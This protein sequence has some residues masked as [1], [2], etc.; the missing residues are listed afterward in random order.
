MANGVRNHLLLYLNLGYAL[1]IVYAS[2][3]PLT[4]WHDSGGDPL[5]FVSAP[6]PRYFTA[7]DLA[8]NVLAYLPFG[9]LCAAALRG[10][11]T[12]LAAGLIAAALGAGLSLALELTQNYLPSRVPSNLDF[13]CNAAGA[14][15]GAML[16]AGW[17]RLVLGERHLALWQGHVITQAYGADLGV[18]LMAAWLMTQLSP[19]TLLFG[20]GDLRQMLDL[21][22]VQTFEP[23]RFVGMETAVAASGLLAA[24]LIASLLLRRRRR[25]LPLLL[26]LLALTTKTLAYALIAGPA[27]AL[28]WLTPGNSQGI[29]IGLALWLGASFLT[30]ALQRATAALALLFAT[31]M[32]NAAPEN[33]YL[34]NMAQLWHSGQFLNFNGLTRLI[35]SLWPFLALPWLM[36]YRP[37]NPHD[38]HF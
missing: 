29:G 21:P 34:N 4:G 8:T 28:T 24:T 31:V 23:E 25:L 1:L 5:S 35:C 2:L 27:A 37:E 32:V 18:L 26:L 17:G 6:W 38:R 30:P 33:P 11:L 36:I 12:P 14:L 10:R 9:F 15:L 3:Y 7:F 13:A 20:V 19:D 16:G 22:P